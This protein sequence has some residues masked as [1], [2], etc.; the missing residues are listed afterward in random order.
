MRKTILNSLVMLCCLFTFV[1]V[2][3][4]AVKK[5]NSTLAAP[6]KFKYCAR[7]YREGGTWVNISSDSL[8]QSISYNDTISLSDSRLKIKKD[9]CTFGGWA[10]DGVS[11]SIVTKSYL[12]ASD[13]PGVCAKLYAVWNNCKQSEPGT[14]SGNKKYTVTFDLTG[15]SGSIASQTI[16]QGGKVK[17]PDNPSKSGYEFLHWTASKGGAVYDFNSSVNSNL[18][19]YATWKKS[20]TTE[21]PS[22]PTGPS[23]PPS[24]PDNPLE[25]KYTVTFDLNGGIG[26]VASQTIEIGQKLSVP[27]DVP[28]KDG[29][30]FEGW[31]TSKSCDEYYDLSTPLNSS[32]TLY[33]CYKEGK[34]IN[35]TIQGLPYIDTYTKVLKD[36]SNLQ[37]FNQVKKIY[38]FDTTT[39]VMSD[40]SRCPSTLKSLHSNLDTDELLEEC[41]N[42]TNLLTCQNNEKCHGDKYVTLDNTESENINYLR[43]NNVIKIEF[44]TYE[45]EGLFNDKEC[46]L[47]YDYDAKIDSDLD[48]YECYKI[49][50]E[51]EVEE[52]I[53]VPKKKKNNSGSVITIMLIIAAIVAV[54]GAVLF[55]I[56]KA[57]VSNSVN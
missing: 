35:I 55:F 37:E 5:I 43:E 16:I 31:S 12:D 47:K 24:T 42:I 26:D 28:T 45:Y 1:F 22:G 36:G 8:F 6:E 52:P 9:G 40:E 18:T 27:S 54:I 10:R 23:I 39:Y 51:N 20:S 25:T 57:K 49:V 53:E 21:T 3:N 48:L 17:R 50:E 33:A 29:E 15:G 14:E 19:L 11:G 56:R 38:L 13:S 4:L 32:L 41:D 44:E 46:N 34:K 30:V 2:G 7:F